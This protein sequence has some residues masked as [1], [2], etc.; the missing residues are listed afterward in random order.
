M[1][2]RFQ[3]PSGDLNHLKFK[4]FNVQMNPKFPGGPLE[5]IYSEYAAPMGLWG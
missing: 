2:K 3:G 4:W 1:D 5:A